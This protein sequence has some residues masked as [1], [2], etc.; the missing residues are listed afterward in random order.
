MFVFNFLLDNKQGLVYQ[1]MTDRWR[2]VICLEKWWKT[3]W[4]CRLKFTNSQ[5]NE[6][7]Q[8]SC[9]SVSFAGLTSQTAALLPV[10]WLPRHV[11]L[12]KQLAKGG[13]S[14]QQTHKTDTWR[15][16]TPTISFAFSWAWIPVPPC[17]NAS[18]NVQYTTLSTSNSH[19]SYRMFVASPPK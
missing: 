10:K 15:Q 12:A 2:L 1:R 18:C 14:S 6:L 11:E 19:G 5:V 3:C 8:T 13:R 9:V 17:P 4:F 7:Q 16:F